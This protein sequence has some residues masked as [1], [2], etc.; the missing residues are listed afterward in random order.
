[1]AD[2]PRPDVTL[3]LARVRAGDERARSDLISQVYDELRG[4]AARLMRREH[5]GSPV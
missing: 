3:L 5:P 2:E 4:V 1:M